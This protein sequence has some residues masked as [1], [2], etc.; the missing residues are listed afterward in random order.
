ME[1]P[2]DFLEALASTPGGF[3]QKQILKRLT[4]DMD[5]AWEQEAQE[6]HLRGS[7]AWGRSYASHHF[8]S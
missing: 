2:L 7:E 8:A 6:D 1:C 3:Q 4:A 5:Q